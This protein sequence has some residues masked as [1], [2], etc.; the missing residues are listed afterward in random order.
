[1][2][3][4]RPVVAAAATAGFLLGGAEWLP[5]GLARASHPYYSYPCPFV[6]GGHDFNGNGS[7]EEAWAWN[8]LNGEWLFEG[9]WGV[10]GDIPTPAASNNERTARSGARR[11]AFGTCSAARPP[12]VLVV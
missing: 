4:L 8:P 6:S 10:F 5:L 11:V 3:H 2:L 1:M 9:S 12:T 7:E